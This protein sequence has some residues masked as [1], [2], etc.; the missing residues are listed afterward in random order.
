MKNLLQGIFHLISSKEF[1]RSP[2]YRDDYFRRGLNNAQ[3]LFTGFGNN[4]NIKN[5]TI[6][7]IGC[8][9]GDACIY[10]ASHGA[11]RVIGMDIDEPGIEY[12]K[13]KL[14]TEYARLSDIVE[15]KLSD[16]N[17]KEQFDIVFSKDCFQYYADPEDMMFQMKRYLKED[18]IMVIRFGPLWKAPYGGHNTYMMKVPWAHLIFPDSVIVRE[19]K[20]LRPDDDAASIEHRGR[21]NKM[22]LKRFLT[23]I[24]NSGLEIVYFKTNVMNARWRRLFN[25]LA[26]PPFLREYFTQNV[27]CILRPPI[28]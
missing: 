18:G 8:G 10:M 22:T 19:R 20:R 13:S 9:L 4:V 23:I 17:I 27:Y 16:E 24:R 7:D 2:D 12:A 15:F 3:V 5:K 14:A 28:S 25:L 1:H 26:K 21:L 6:I 11:A